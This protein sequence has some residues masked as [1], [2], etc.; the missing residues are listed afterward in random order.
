MHFKGTGVLKDV[1]LAQMWFNIASANG[2]EKAG[3]NW[4]LLERRMS[5]A[6]IARATALA[7]KCMSSNCKTCGGLSN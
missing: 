7:R 5:K 3:K 6:A 4:D 2:D 1:V